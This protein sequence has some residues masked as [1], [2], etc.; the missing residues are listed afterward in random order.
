MPRSPQA[1]A[2]PLD[3]GQACSAA[4]LPHSPY[5][6]AHHKLC[7]MR[8]GSL[9]HQAKLKHLEHLATTSRGKWPR[10][11]GARPIDP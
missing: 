1:C 8:P 10:S 5:C 7:Y 3:A 9:R 6:D 11:W 2:Y 4:A